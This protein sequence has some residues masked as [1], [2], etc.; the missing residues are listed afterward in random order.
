MTATTLFLDL[1]SPYAYLAAERV[2]SVIPGPVDFQ[3]VLLGAIFQRRGWGS[4]AQTE[5]RAVGMAEDP[6]L[7]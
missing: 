1:G 2:H 7:E 5:H 4:W 6:A 3:P